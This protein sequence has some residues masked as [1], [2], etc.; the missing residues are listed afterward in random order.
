DLDMVGRI[1][2]Q[3]ATY[4]IEHYGTQEH[5]YDVPAFIRR[6]D[7]SFPDYAGRLRAEEMLTTAS[8]KA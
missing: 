3:A 5:V 6:F 2:A 1:A 4:P 8:A 7:E